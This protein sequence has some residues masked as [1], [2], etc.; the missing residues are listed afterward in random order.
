M[1][2]QTEYVIARDRTVDD[3]GDTFE[4]WREIDRINAANL[5]EAEKLLKCKIQNG[6]ISCPEGCRFTIGTFPVGSMGHSITVSCEELM[7]D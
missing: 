2:E 1:A 7:E 3:K 5:E 4:A 6:E